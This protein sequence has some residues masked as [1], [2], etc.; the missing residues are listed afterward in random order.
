MQRKVSYDNIKIDSSLKHRLSA[1]GGHS[2]KCGKISLFLAV[3]TTSVRQANNGKVRILKESVMSSFIV[4]TTEASF[5]KE[6][7]GE[8]IK[9]RVG[10]SVLKHQ[11]LGVVKVSFE[12]GQMFIDD[13]LAI[14]YAK[15][16]LENQG[17]THYSDT[18][19]V[20]DSENPMF[21]MMGHLIGS[22][23][24]RVKD[25][26][27]M[28]FISTEKLLAELTDVI[29]LPDAILDFLVAN[30]NDTAVREYLTS[31]L[32]GSFWHF[33]SFWGTHYKN[34]Y[35]DNYCV[36]ALFYF[37]DEHGT[38]G[39]GEWFW[40]HNYFHNPHFCFFAPLIIKPDDF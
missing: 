13:K 39:D 34:K 29:V 6:W 33:P 19:M 12:N 24:E 8:E 15:P 31:L 32:K 17:Q 5:P 16:F 4:D 25:V 38:M 36:R 11:S 1:I 14:V 27:G 28:G 26:P 35:G 18:G 9:Q 22:M 10:W 30:Q 20:S 21:V 23:C 37:G 40:I 2:Q 7:E 3:T